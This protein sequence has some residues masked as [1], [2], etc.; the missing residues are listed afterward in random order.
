MLQVFSQKTSFLQK[1]IFQSEGRLRL[2]HLV[3]FSV[4]EELALQCN[5]Y[6]YSPSRPFR[7]PIVVQVYSLKGKG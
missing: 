2:R 4:T 3:L 1:S 5:S 6:D 7:H